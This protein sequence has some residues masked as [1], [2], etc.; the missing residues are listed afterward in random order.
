MS[1]PTAKLES[2]LQGVA[3]RYIGTKPQ[4]TDNVCGTDTVWKGFGDIQIV[5][6]PVAQR[7]LATKFNAIWQRESDT[8]PDVK[9]PVRA[10][11]NARNAVKAHA[12]K[13]A[14][15]PQRP[16]S[17]Y[18]TVPLP[19]IID[20]ICTLT[21]KEDGASHFGEDSRPKLESVREQLGKNN[22]QQQ[23]TQAWDEIVSAKA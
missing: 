2:A 18:V 19:D 12:E 14:A 23:L 11:N 17:E 8:P 6:L 1:T 10:V 4:K 20:A 22:N 5:P 21:E 15:R 13:V 16:Q 9:D 3:I 7:L